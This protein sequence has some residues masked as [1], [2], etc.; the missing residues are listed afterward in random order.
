MIIIVKRLGKTLVF[1]L[2]FSVL[3]LQATAGYPADVIP[4]TANTTATIAVGTPN[5]GEV[6]PAGSTHTI[7][8][9]YTGDPGPTVK[10]E[11]LKDT[12]VIM[13]V[14]YG[15]SVGSS[16]S[17][18]YALTIPPSM[19][20]GSDY[21]IRITST[22]NSSCYDISDGFFT[23]TPD[24]TSLTLVTPNGGETWQQGST[25]KIE[26]IYTGDP[27]SHVKIDF[28]KGPTVLGNV[29]ASIGT[30][31]SGS[32]SLTIPYNVPA[33]SDYKIRV[34]ST[35]KPAYTDTSNASFTIGSAITVSTPNGGESWPEG[36][37]QTIRWT[38]QGNPGSTVLIDV[39][40]GPTILANITASTSIGSGGAGEY[41]LPI[42]SSAPVGED[43]R[44]KVTSTSYPA[45]TDLSDMPFS[46]TP[47][48]ATITLVT[49]NG[50]ET[51]QQGATWPIQW[52]YTGNPGSHVKIDLLKGPTALGNVT[53][54]IGSGGSGSYSLTLPYDVPAGADYRIRVSSTT[55][56]HCSDTSETFSTINSA[57]TLTSPN[58]G[59]NWSQGSVHAIRWNFSGNPGPAVKITLLKGPT[60]LANITESTSLG[61]G[62]SG[63]YTL[64]I[65]M[66]APL[67]TEFRI[68]ITSTSHPACNDTSE[69]YF[70][71]VPGGGSISVMTPNG[72]EEWQQ[73]S[74]K[75]LQWTY[76]GDPGSH[77]KIEVIKGSA[78]KVITPS[79]PIGTGGFGSYNLTFPYTTPLGSDYLVRVT[80][81]SNPAYTD[82]SDTSFTISPNVGT[83]SLETPNGGEEWQQG[84]TPTIRWA[85]TG[86]PG[87]TVKIEISKGTAVKVITA[88]TSIG[89]EG[90]G[91]FGLMIPYNTPLGSDYKVRV[92]STTNGAFTDTSSGPFTIS[93]A[94]RVATPNGGENYPIGSPLPMSW[95]YSGTPGST[96]NIDVI[97]GGAVLKTLT[98]IPLG[99][100]G[101]G[102]YPV[103][104]PASTPQGTDYLIRV[105]SG[106]Y[107][108]CTDTSNG[109]FAI[110]AAGG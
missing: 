53:V 6:W 25:K 72:G 92:T 57:L 29:T 86:D 103:T 36:S 10:I 19:P 91:S 11:M 22:S 9:T 42:P 69:G 1:L 17:G 55:K 93:S 46:I 61:S 81:T 100:S 77:V 30:G 94:I 105:T 8:W 65:P 66:S 39:L 75:T 59:E 89:S 2:I 96:V 58:G 37:L 38:Y 79:T 102:S 4:A 71:I 7:T 13:M 23:I 44:I 87:P 88:G 74:T 56:P 73:G 27:G 97:K 47:D 40:K 28:L 31:G 52:T 12:S 26:W 67:G 76:T 68:R 48:N 108:A 110:S 80:S 95:T 104:I 20:T 85:Y 32:F 64:P 109:T 51:L 90:I 45:Y 49:P 99:A 21:R 43:F 62:G 5:G 107:A 3:F 84:S 18:T 83:I 35:S 60:V 15:T 54:S 63:Q 34:T 41:T 106:T 50:G 82:T 16:G 78:V 14:S 33:G 24:T 101:S 98:G 70:S